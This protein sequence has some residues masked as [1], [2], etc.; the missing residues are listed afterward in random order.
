MP[1]LRSL[2][3]AASLLILLGT[4]GWWYAQDAHSGWSQNRVPVTQTDEITGITYTTY[5]DRFVPGLDTLG[6][7]VLVAAFLLATTFFIRSNRNPQS[8]T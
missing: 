5:E 6:L 8:S 7:G 4:L 1:A 2:L 3:R